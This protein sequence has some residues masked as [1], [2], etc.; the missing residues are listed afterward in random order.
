[1]RT[2]SNYAQNALFELQLR[3]VNPLME[4][5]NRVYFREGNDT[6]RTGFHAG[7]SVYLNFILSMAF[8]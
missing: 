1:M 8:R 7:M 5:N 3:L 6:H 4:F 2:N